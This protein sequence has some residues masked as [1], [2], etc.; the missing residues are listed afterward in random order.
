MP[1]L[2]VQEKIILQFPRHAKCVMLCFAQ[3]TE[4]ES[5]K[6]CYYF[7]L[8]RKLPLCCRCHKLHLL[9]LYYFYLHLDYTVT[10]IY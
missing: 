1:R 6:T 8:Y 10:T 7:K 5:G 4:K 2:S 9:S 3:S